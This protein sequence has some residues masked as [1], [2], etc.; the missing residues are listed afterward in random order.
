MKQ[1]TSI[2]MRL[3]RHRGVLIAILLALVLTFTGFAHLPVAHAAPALQTEYGCP[4]G[5][6][7]VY[8]ERYIDYNHPSNNQPLNEY[9]YYG[10]YQFHGH[11]YH[12]YVN[13]QYAG[14]LW[15][16]TDWYG[17]NCPVGMMP[18]GGFGNV[19]WTTT[20]SIKLTPTG[21]SGY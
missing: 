19:N 16:C 7:C 8:L 11:G 14:W 10:V 1:S 3:S 20:Y 4:P 15:F 9:Y 6:A 21:P 17:N 2:F 13:N 18:G 12:A 5:Y